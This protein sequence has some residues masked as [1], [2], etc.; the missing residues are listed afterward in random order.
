MGEFRMPSLG[1][2][3]EAGTLVEWLKKPGDA[4][5]HGDAIAVVETQKGAIEIDAFEDGILDR[6]LVEIGAKVPVGT[7]LAFIHTTGEAPTPAAP[8]PPPKVAAPP[9][10]TARAAMPTPPVIPAPAPPPASSDLARVSPAARKLAAERGVPL[11]GIKGTGPGGAIVSAD[12][13][14]AVPGARAEAVPAKRHGLNLA[15]MRKAIAAAMARSKREIPHYYLSHTIDMSAALDWLKAVNATREPPQRLLLAAMLLKAVALA[16]EEFPEFNGV[17]TDGAFHPS[18]G[19]HVGTAIAIRG[20]GLVAP[21]IRDADEKTLDELMAALR[22]LVARTRAGRLRSSELFEPTI[23][24]SSLGERGVESL[25][26]VIY[27]PQVAIVGFG[28]PA[29]QPR[30]ID[31]RIESRPVI[32]VTL[33]ADHRASDG[34]R[35]ALLLLEIERLLQHPE[36]L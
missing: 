18:E 7:P 30:A 33:A 27:P 9:P 1:A 23:T 13:E 31:G 28:T 21:A 16:L 20:G 29:P 19:I 25:F 24:V 35:G 17:Y 6:P 5:K 3:M 26:G 11:A 22:G 14:Q 10:P 8:S 12:I 15:E 4:V 2:D 34:H 36:A 32:T